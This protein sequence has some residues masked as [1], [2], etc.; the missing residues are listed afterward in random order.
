ML[1]LVEDDPTSA[2]QIAS[3]IIS[4]KNPS[5]GGT[6]RL[7]QAS[8]GK[9]YPLVPGSSSKVEP[10]I[11]SAEDLVKVQTNTGLSKNKMKK[12]VT[13]LNS[14]PGGIVERNIH[15]KF[16][17]LSK[18]MAD[19][20]ELSN[21][22]INDWEKKSKQTKPIVHCKNLEELVN[23]VVMQRGCGTNHFVKVGIDSGGSFLKITL[24]VVETF[25]DEDCGEASKS[26]FSRSLT[27]SSSKDT[28]VNKLLIA[29]IGDIPETYENL[30]TLI[31]LIQWNDVLF[32]ISCD[33]KVANLL[34]GIQSHSSKHPC[35][36]CNI[37][38]ENLSSC[39]ESRTFG[40]IKQS[41]SNF[42]S[43]GAQIKF[44]KNFE[45]VI[46]QPLINFEDEKLVLDVIP[47]M[48][49]HLFLGIV[50]HLF[51]CLLEIWPKAQ[52]WPTLLHLQIQPFHG[53]H[54]NG[55]DCH[56]LLEN[57]D[58]LQVLAENASAFE[59]IPFVDCFRKF[60]AVVKSCFGA[61]VKPDFIEEISK[62]K[63]SYLSLG[64]SVTPKAHA[65]FFHISEFIKKHQTGLGI[66]SEQAVESTHSKFK[67]HWQRYKRSPLHPSYGEKLLQCVVDFNSKHV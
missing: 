44:A 50:N 11:F 32:F 26:V 42:I 57:I 60:Q 18:S 24:N 43:S 1:S 6:I 52:E 29:A 17:T 16:G 23:Q 58:K 48:E 12:L 39:G 36:W 19:F 45:N 64:V 30:K 41:F 27:K 67:T 10:P 47:P 54:F 62:F 34:C 31:D 4:K 14:L 2:E 25:E 13:S 65:V 35:C 9:L 59:A 51:K 21:I 15:E 63:D 22:E 53:G 40:S 66:Y 33:M 49:L 55:N 28:G 20:F 8:R 5:P 3:D 61:S 46:H 38:S 7:S 56:K 37:S